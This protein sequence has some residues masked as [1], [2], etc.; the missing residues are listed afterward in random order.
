MFNAKLSIITNLTFISANYKAGPLL[1]CKD[2]SKRSGPFSLSSLVPILYFASCW[3]FFAAPRIF[4]S[5]EDIW[6][7]VQHLMRVRFLWSC[8]SSLRG[9]KDQIPGLR[10]SHRSS[11][12]EGPPRKSPTLRVSRLRSR[13]LCHCFQCW[14][15]HLPVNPSF[16]SQLFHPGFRGHKGKTGWTKKV[17]SITHPLHVFPYGLTQCFSA[18]AAFSLLSLAAECIV[19]HSTAT[20]TPFALSPCPGTQHQLQVPTVDWLP[21]L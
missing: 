5:D 2:S 19:F 3:V 16:A 9:Q 1:L 4:K 21:G 12:L 6:I 15:G 10:G 13:P 20:I 17:T 18:P 11:T 7:L 14:P 8:G